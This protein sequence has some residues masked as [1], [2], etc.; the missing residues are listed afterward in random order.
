MIIAHLTQLQLNIH[1]LQGVCS[2]INAYIFNPGSLYWY[3][4]TYPKSSKRSIIESNLSYPASVPACLTIRCKV[5]ASHAHTFSHY[6]LELRSC[7]TC[8]QC[9]DQSESIV[10]EVSLYN[11]T[12]LIETFHIHTYSACTHPNNLCLMSLTCPSTRSLTVTV[13]T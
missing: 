7:P 5:A 11:Y 2:N 3:D 1:E 10:V 13:H 12:Q 4:K 6:L 8:D 9:P